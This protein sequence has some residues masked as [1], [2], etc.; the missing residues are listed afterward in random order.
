MVGFWPCLTEG[1]KIMADCIL[2]NYGSRGRY[3]NPITSFPLWECT[4]AVFLLCLW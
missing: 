2:Y 1:R 4:D 3:S